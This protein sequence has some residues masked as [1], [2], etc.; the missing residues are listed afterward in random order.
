[1]IEVR[2]MQLDDLEAVMAIENENFS[3]PWT[4]TGFFS[5][6]I[7]EDT[8]FLVACEAEE[9]L[10]YCG[11]VMVQDE[12]DITNVAVAGGRQNQGIGKLLMKAL[13]EKTE[14]AGVRHLFLEVR[15]SNLHAVHLYEE[16]GFMEIGLRKN[17]YE[18]PIEDGIVMKRG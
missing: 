17:Y 4:E 15:V 12:G 1:M 11:V 3:K 16:M 7:R 5:F 18:A 8:L 2:E 14:Q 9:I 6:L 10:G 13:I